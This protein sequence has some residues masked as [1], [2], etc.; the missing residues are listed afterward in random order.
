MQTA[1]R[2]S[3]GGCAA[4]SRDDSAASAASVPAVATGRSRDATEHVRGASDVIIVGGGISG[5][6]GACSLAQAG[7]TVTLLEADCRLGGRL[8]QVDAYPGYGLIDMGGELVEGEHSVL[9]R[10]IEEKGW[11]SHEAFDDRYVKLPLRKM[12]RQAY[13][14]D[15]NLF[16]DDSPFFQQLLDT[17]SI[18][19]DGYEA[20]VAKQSDGDND[21]NMMDSSVGELLNA[22]SV[23]STDIGYRLIESTVCQRDGVCIDECSAAMECE[24][25]DY[26]S[27]VR[28]LDGSFSLLLQ[29]YVDIAYHLR[30]CLSIQLNNAVKS[31]TYQCSADQNV[32]DHQVAVVTSSGK[33]YASK[34]ALVT[35]PLAVLQ[36]HGIHFN[37]PLPRRLTSTIESLSMQ[38]AMKVYLRFTK[39]F[40]PEDIGIL[41]ST[42]GFLKQFWM[43][44]PHF[45]DDAKLDSTYD[46]KL[47]STPRQA[48]NTEAGTHEIDTSASNDVTTMSLPAWRQTYVPYVGVTGGKHSGSN[49]T[50]QNGHRGD[51]L[52]MADVGVTMVRR[53]DV[54][55]LPH[56]TPA[57]GETEQSMGDAGSVDY[58][59]HAGDGPDIGV[60]DS[61]NSHDAP[62][63]E[64]KQP[65]YAMFGFATSRVAD[66]VCELAPA[67]LVQRVLHQLDEMFG[68]S[69]GDDDGDQV[70][71]PAT[72]YFHSA[73]VMCWGDQ[74][75]VGGGYCAP[76]AGARRHK[77]EFHRPVDDRIYFAGE[78]VH[79]QLSSVH[80]AMETGLD[81]AE[82]ISR[83]LSPAL[84]TCSQSA[85]ER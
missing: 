22:A 73:L 64:C 35:V 47:C 37:P 71:H 44:A 5:L 43:D 50:P 68:R 62:R 63:Q 54:Q 27:L 12:C 8:L 84:S 2:V 40:W 30:H 25:W 74:E 33:T 52:D 49:A 39:C 83:Y 34:V 20:I 55:T 85:G 51:C 60:T 66:S 75:F 9:T 31:I 57:S 81:A 18:V 70:S 65:F 46:S 15:E 6:V 72:E 59:G 17:W 32:N 80:T 48:S 10:L 29:H 67:Q 14:A 16:Y 56:C 53:E 79:Q 42:D 7:F 76:S 58:K 11:T 13:Y 21:A 28:R 26:G 82:K 41:Y 4:L 69:D 61:R 1:A 38:N 3:S 77:T 36:R 24:G 78:H 19:E 45:Y 23:P